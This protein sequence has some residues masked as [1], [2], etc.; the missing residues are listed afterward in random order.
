[1]RFVP[2]LFDTGEHI[3]RG[4]HSSEGSADQDPAFGVYAVSVQQRPQ[5]ESLGL[6]QERDSSGKVKW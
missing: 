5:A 6:L 1:M 2:L 4:L 3:H